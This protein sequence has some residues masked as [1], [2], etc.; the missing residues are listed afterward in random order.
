MHC[1]LLRQIPQHLWG[2]GRAHH[3]M[4][5]FQDGTCASVFLLTRVL[6]CSSNLGLGC[7]GLSLVLAAVISNFGLFVSLPVLW[8]AF[9]S[10][11]RGKGLGSMQLFVLLLLL[12]IIIIKT[13][14]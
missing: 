7:L 2:F 11:L 9:R 5:G 10:C 12:Y 14:F 13:Y 6:Y 3:A 4:Q 1:V 8:K